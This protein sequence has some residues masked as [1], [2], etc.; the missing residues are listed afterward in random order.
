[1]CSGQEPLLAELF[2][3]FEIDFCRLTFLPLYGYPDVY[4]T[5]SPL[6]LPL[7]AQLSPSLT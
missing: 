1:M 4:L 6:H 5:E 2:T 3:V 7:Q